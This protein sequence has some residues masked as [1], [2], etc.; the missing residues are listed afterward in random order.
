MLLI[1][2][3]TFFNFFSDFIVYLD[4][5]WY[6]FSR[7]DIT[8]ILLKVALNTITPSIYLIDYKLCMKSHWMVSYRV[9]ICC[10]HRKAWYLQPTLDI[11]N[12]T[13]TLKY[14]RTAPVV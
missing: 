12:V 1:K 7:H 5:S 6:S 11:V 8:E 10:V 4:V 9:L 2:I 13:C 3:N 14:L